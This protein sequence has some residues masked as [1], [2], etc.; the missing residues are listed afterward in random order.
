MK[1][2]TK[3]AQCGKKRMRTDAVRE[4]RVNNQ[5]VNPKMGNARILLNINRK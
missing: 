2:K 5:Q 4:V 3:I 1:Q